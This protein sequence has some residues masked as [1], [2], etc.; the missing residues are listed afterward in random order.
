METKQPNEIN[1]IPIQ[2]SSRPGFGTAEIVK[3][4]IGTAECYNPEIFPE[5]NRYV[6][7]FAMLECMIHEMANTEERST[8]HQN[9]MRNMYNEYND[10]LYYGL[11]FNYV[12]MHQMH[13]H[14]LTSISQQN[15]LIF[16]RERY[17]FEALPVAGPLKPFF[18]AMN[19]AK[20]QDPSFGPVVPWKPN[21]HDFPLTANDC[22]SYAMP[23]MHM[24][25]DMVSLIRVHGQAVMDQ[26]VGQ[27]QE[28]HF[29]NDIWIDNAKPLVPHPNTNQWAGNRSRR[30]TSW[31]PGFISPSRALQYPNVYKNNSAT[32]R[33]PMILNNRNIHSELAEHAFD[34]DPD[35]FTRAI[36]Q[37]ART[38]RFWPGSTTL[39]RLIARDT[40][41]GKHVLEYCD[42][43]E[44]VANGLQLPAVL[45]HEPA[46][47]ANALQIAQARRRQAFE[48]LNHLRTQDTRRPFAI[49]TR[50]NLLVREPTSVIMNQNLG[51]VTGVNKVPI[52]D[53][54][55]NELNIDGLVPIYYG[56]YWNE[57]LK[58]KGSRYVPIYTYQ[59]TPNYD[60]NFALKPF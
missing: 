8:Y 12:T 55:Y 57:T 40:G 14:G 50:Q 51:T 37:Q 54:I 22:Q 43:E 58:F 3:A 45:N 30:W 19:S 6:P 41:S 29:D 20:P 2:S 17:P 46:N 10:R 28:Y 1:P 44:I 34:L 18:E 36:A 33:P 35:W 27:N 16:M 47:D 23:L 9:E 32:I 39:D 26:N 56:P 11:L 52:I 21:L 42:Y 53:Y 60:V 49:R 59:T 25:P 4:L 5:C 15:F 48:I 13:L 7:N 24:L 31:K 38:V